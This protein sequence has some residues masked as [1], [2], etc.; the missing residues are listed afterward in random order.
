LG[1]PV[2]FFGELRR[3]NVFRMGIAYLAAVWVLIEVTDTLV[4]I[5][6]GP[7]WIPQA[8]V[9]SGAL[10]FPLALV[11]AWFYELT[12]EGI[13]STADIEAVEAVKFTGRKLDFAI[14]GLLV[15]ALGF[16]V[17]DQ[18][19]VEESGQAE[20]RDLRS[21]AALPFA[22]ESAEEENAEF[23]ANGI[24]DELLTQL[25]KVGSLKVISRTSVEEYRDTSK[26]M[27]QIGQELGVAT[28]LE[29]R[30][31]R[32]GDMVRINVQ[33]IDAE[34]DQHLWAENYDRELTAESIFA[35][36]SEMA[37]SIADAL[38]VTLTPQE[39]AQLD[40][41]PTQ[42]TRAWD[43]YLSG[44]EYFNRRDNRNSGPLAIQQ[45][46]RAVEVDPEFAQAWAA[47]SRAHS[48]MYLYSGRSEEAHLDAARQAVE[49][50]FVLAPDAPEA[51]IAMATYHQ[52]GTL[53][54]QAALRELAIA[55]QGMP[56]TADIFKTRAFIQ[57]R[58]NDWEDAR[59]NMARAAELDP[60]NVDT[61]G[62]LTGTNLHLRDY[63]AAER[64]NDR[65]LDIAPDSRGARL[66]QVMIPMARDGDFT[67]LKAMVESGRPMPNRLH[68]AWLGALYEGD[69]ERAVQHLEEW[70]V[71]ADV[72]QNWY[73]PIASYYGVTHHL[74]G[75]SELAA[76]QF[77][78][79][80]THLE[81]AWESAPEDARLHVALGEAMLGLGDRDEAIR[82]AE[83]ATELMPRTTDA[84]NA[85]W[86]QL[87]AI[88]RVLAPAGFSDVLIEQLDDYL[89]QN[90]WWSIEG[91]L[92]DPRLDPIRDESR[93]QAVVEKYRR[94]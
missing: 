9:F 34:T 39:V 19:V 46:E 10:G 69:Y 73:V 45:Y 84:L 85:S 25:A 64:T 55:E 29:G 11:L 51:H 26:N 14:I 30:V 75:R 40:V 71:E 82:L 6:N 27:R 3:R 20:L 63:A 81:Q 62:H 56:G 93:F 72:T 58:A 57:R 76:S 89:T 8:L 42:S 47:L 12:P 94:R 48:S 90:G 2:S 24:H 38:Q 33:L 17:V 61:L 5:I 18:Y 16:V 78:E 13:K 41:V 79:A 43:F 59:V 28:L 23:F 36:Q 44:N 83:R 91:L 88:V 67:I 7:A 32:A 31:Q 70:R 35:I 74:A 52:N 92:G 65:V 49:R 77:Q 50:A 53:D 1:E 22:N 80:Y 37:T 68:N 60:R 87:D 54:Y 15:F 66:S 86:I 21:I 4:A